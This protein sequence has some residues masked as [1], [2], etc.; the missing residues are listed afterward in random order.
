MGPRRSSV[1]P[2]MAPPFAELPEKTRAPF[3]TR[4]NDFSCISPAFYDGHVV[5]VGD[6]FSTFWPHVGLATEQAALHSISLETPIIQAECL[7]REE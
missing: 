6:V 7:L 3:V 1:L 2:Q 5:F 4:I